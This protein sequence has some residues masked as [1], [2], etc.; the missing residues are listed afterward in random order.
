M[1]I[2]DNL[3]TVLNLLQDVAPGNQNIKDQLG[4]ISKNRN[5]FITQLQEKWQSR[6][7]PTHTEMDIKTMNTQFYADEELN[8]IIAETNGRTQ[9]KMNSRD[10]IIKGADKWLGW[11]AENSV[12]FP[13]P[14]LFEGTLDFKRNFENLVVSDRESGSINLIW[15]ISKI[16]DKGINMCLSD[17]N[18]ISCFLHLAK[19]YL[20]NNYQA[21]SR[22]SANLEGLFS[23]LVSS[24]NGDHEISKLRTCMSKLCRKPGEMVQSCLFKL[25]AQ[26]EMLLQIS[27]PAMD[28][29]SITLR[30]DNYASNCA[31]YFVSSNTGKICEQ[32][33]SYK[34]SR[35]NE[36]SVLKISN[37][38]TQHEALNANDRITTTHTLPESGCKLDLQM[39][40]C[41]NVED[42][43]VQTAQM[44]QSGRRSKSPYQPSKGY[45]RSPSQNRPYYRDKHQS[46]SPSTERKHRPSSRGREYQNREHQNRDHKKETYQQGRYRSKTNSMDRNPKNRNTSTHKDKGDKYGNSYK[47]NRQEKSK[48]PSNRTRG[49]TPDQRDANQVKCIRCGDPHFAK[50][51]TK[52]VFYDGPSCSV[53][54]FLHKTR[55]HRQRSNSVDRSSQNLGARKKTHVPDFKYRDLDGYQMQIQGANLQS[56]E[57]SDFNLF[58]KKN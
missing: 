55:D 24:V 42:L 13:L 26:Y 39:Y 21:L 36:N 33:I 30:A 25:R 23:T 43:M 20:P 19:N 35:G 11:D 47:M 28:E 17:D 16:L 1:E 3:E 51:C 54:N 37:L 31:K 49:R 48:S 6:T 27:F 50:L 58:N 41:N 38:I 18:W 5:T 29:A 8:K 32:Y 45:S 53:C 12:Y 22:Y 7:Q 46:K 57:Q 14:I 40:Q 44:Q 4:K 52:Y 9:N 2:S 34:I 15:T 10:W 56:E